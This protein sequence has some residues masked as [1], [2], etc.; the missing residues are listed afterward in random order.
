MRVGFVNPVRRRAGRR[1]SVATH[2]RVQASARLRLAV[3]LINMRTCVRSGRPDATRHAGRT[4]CEPLF[5]SAAEIDTQPF[6][7]WFARHGQQQGTNISIRNIEWTS[8][9]ARVAPGQD[10]IQFLEQADGD[11]L[12]CIG[13]GRVIETYYVRNLIALHV[14]YESKDEQ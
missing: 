6:G 9:R 11:E 3:S 13:Y 2:A 14:D 10:K 7:R 4:G 5:P 12:W 8:V 1:V